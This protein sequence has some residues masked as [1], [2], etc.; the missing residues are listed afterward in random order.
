MNTAAT[1]PGRKRDPSR[2][3]VIL[4]AALDVLADQG[5][6]GMTVDAV[7]ARAKAGKGTVAAARR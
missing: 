2:D 3:A 4:D 6:D 7:A 1:R 5:Y